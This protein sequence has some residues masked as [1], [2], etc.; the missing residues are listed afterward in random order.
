[1]YPPIYGLLRDRSFSIIY[2][3]LYENVYARRISICIF[4]IVT[5][6]RGE[7]NN[8]WL[9]C[10]KKPIHNSCGLSFV[11]HQQNHINVKWLENTVNQNLKEQFVP[12]K[13]NSELDSSSKG[14][15]Y[16]I[17]KSNFCCEDYLLLL[18][19]RKLRTL[20]VKYRTTN[21]HFPIEIGRWNSTPLE[22]RKCG[23]CEANQFGDEFH[24]VLECSGLSH[25][26][27]KLFSNNYLKT[28]NVKI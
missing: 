2:N 18:L 7:I 25:V 9:V 16:R 24:Y 1:M 22:D 27:K 11:W 19:P 23:L 5:L 4:T 20:F 26:R 12:E 17:F 14:A 13:W 3:S 28:K 15:I 10:I 6:S 21:H 8:S